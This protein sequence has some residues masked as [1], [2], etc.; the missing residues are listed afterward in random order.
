MMALFPA[1][2][3]RAV[4]SLHCAWLRLADRV[5]PAAQSRDESD[6]VGELVGNEGWKLQCSAGRRAYGYAI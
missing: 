5:E 4:V 3:K 6:P 2:L 1:F